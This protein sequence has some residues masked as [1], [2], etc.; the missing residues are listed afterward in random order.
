[1]VNAIQGSTYVLHIASVFDFSIP[2]AEMIAT[3]VNGT[4][5]AL[6]A[7]QAAGVRRIVI[8]SSCAAIW[9][10]AE[11][12]KPADRM[13][14]ESHW[15]NPN[16][17][18]P[19]LPYFKSKVIAEKAAWDFHAALPADQKFELVTINAAKIMGPPLRKERNLSSEWCKSVMLGTMET[20]SS[21]HVCVVDVRDAA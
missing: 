8:T 4:I 17:P 5:F 1:M 12:D 21:D 7:C 2:E 16:R 14:D 20:V 6:K 9:N 10:M 13:F 19:L 11:A 15:A 3:A 18:E